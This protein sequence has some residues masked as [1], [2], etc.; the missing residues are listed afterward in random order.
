MVIFLNLN[1]GLKKSPKNVIIV[2]K[3]SVL[4]WLTFVISGLL[5]ITFQSGKLFVICFNA[6]VLYVCATPGLYSHPHFPCLFV[7]VLKYIYKCTHSLMN[8]F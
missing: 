3:D 6:S 2:L 4:H 5:Q 7:C 1:F 8:I